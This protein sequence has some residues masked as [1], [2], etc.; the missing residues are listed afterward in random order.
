MEYPIVLEPDPE[1]EGYVMSAPHS[2]GYAAERDTEKEAL[3]NINAA[4]KI[5]RASIKGLKQLKELRTVE[6]SV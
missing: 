6:V 2:Q 5:H 3:D 1:A 4:F